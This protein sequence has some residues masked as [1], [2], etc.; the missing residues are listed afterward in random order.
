MTSQNLT[1]E[2][3]VEIIREKN[4]ELY[5]EIIKRYQIKLSHYLKKF[6]YDSDELEDVLQV[7][8]IKSYKNLYGFNIHKKFS[9]WIYRIAHNEAIN[10]LKKNFRG[11]ISLE[12]VEY[13]IIDEKINL[14]DDIDKIL[15]KKKVEKY[16]S[17]ISLKYRGPLILFYF[18]QKSY[19]EISDIMHIPKNTVGTL[20]LR[21]KQI[22]KENLSQRKNYEK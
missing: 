5:S 15:L 3:L 21:G 12:E 6:I 22:L 4:Q 14:H 16:L 11:Q 19:Q 9:S 20:I 13:K 10:Y 7:V 18:E 1:D 2:Q 17:D 8:F